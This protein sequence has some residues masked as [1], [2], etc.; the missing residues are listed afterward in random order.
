VQGSC[1]RVEGGHGAPRRQSAFL[2]AVQAGMQALAGIR[3]QPKATVQAP[4][5]RASWSKGGGR[6]QGRLVHGC[7]PDLTAPPGF[8]H[9]PTQTACPLRRSAMPI[10]GPRLM[11]SPPSANGSGDGGGLVVC[12][13]LF[14]GPSAHR[15][16]QPCV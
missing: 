1:A 14:H 8:S 9:A 13:R 3:Q 12:A 6:G 2:Q 16:K 7:P 5:G 11:T 10:V 4:C 15:H